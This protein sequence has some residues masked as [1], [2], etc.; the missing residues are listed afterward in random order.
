MTEQDYE[1]T[2]EEIAR[3]EAQAEQA[4]WEQNNA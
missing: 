2:E 3:I 4:I 1:I